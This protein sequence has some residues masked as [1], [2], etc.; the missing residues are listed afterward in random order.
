MSERLRIPLPPKEIVIDGP[1]Y[2]VISNWPFDDSDSSVGRLLRTD[3]PDRVQFNQ[4]RVWIYHDPDGQIVG[5]GTLDICLDYSEHTGGRPHPYIPLLA[6]NPGIKSQGYGTTIVQ[7]LI[8]EAAVLARQ[9]LCGETIYLDVYVTSARAIALYE[10]ED[11]IKIIDEPIPDPEQGHL[12][13]YI[14]ARRAIVTKA[15]TL[16][17]TGYR[18]DHP[19]PP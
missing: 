11:F 2:R 8:G 10:R 12:P 9:G 6:V 16:T 15:L 4:G 18:G 3:V 19:G 17:I 5:F 7:Q 13:Y 1:E 14:M